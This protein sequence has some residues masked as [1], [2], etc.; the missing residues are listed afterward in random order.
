MFR[1][2]F[3][4]QVSDMMVVVSLAEQQQQVRHSFLA[5]PVLWIEGQAFAGQ[6]F[7]VQ[8]FANHSIYLPIF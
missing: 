2:Y 4:S 6:A 3:A 5:A 1:A 8:V 7:A